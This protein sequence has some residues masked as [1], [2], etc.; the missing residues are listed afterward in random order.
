MLKI[1]PT[2][3]DNILIAAPAVSSCDYDDLCTEIDGLLRQS[4]VSC[5]EELADK[6]FLI[7]GLGLT[8]NECRIL[9]AGADLLTTRRRERGAGGWD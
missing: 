6:V 7:E 8:H 1:E 3:A 4:R 9:S 5:A 2:E